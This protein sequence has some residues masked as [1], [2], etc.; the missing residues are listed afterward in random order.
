MSCNNKIESLFKD[1]NATIKK[2][3]VI[4]N[5]LLFYFL[6][7]FGFNCIHLTKFLS[8]WVLRIAK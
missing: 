3:E 4:L 8:L 5:N 2:Y 7:L 1:I 6:G